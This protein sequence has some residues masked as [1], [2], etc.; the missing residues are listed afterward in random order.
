MSI[1]STFLVIN[2]KNRTQDSKSSSDFQYYIGQPIEVNSIV[3][4][5]VSIPNTA[6]NITT[7]NNVMTV[8]INGT[9]RTITLTPGQYS[10]AQIT[11]I[12]EAKF[13]EFG[14]VLVLSQNPYTNIL[15][16]T[17]DVNIQFLPT[18]SNSLTTTLGWVFDALLAPTLSITFRYIPKLQGPLNYYILSKTLG[19]GSNGRF[20]GG[21]QDAYLASVPNTAPF[22]GVNLYE[23]HIIET[24]MN[25][26]RTSINSQFIDIQIVTSDL[27]P[28][29]LNGA[30]VELI[31]KL[32]LNVQTRV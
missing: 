9:V 4:K 26:Y 27:V 23:P 7:A 16:F 17:S 20:T 8:N 18:I 5:S 29:D 6:Y 15:T 13:L 31:F 12:L 19:I 30:E 21:L 25:S 24:S 32:Y 3:L 1:S 11:L 14:S 22:L 28:I 10:M 2:S